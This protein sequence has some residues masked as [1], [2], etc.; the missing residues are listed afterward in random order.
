MSNLAFIGLGVMG[1]PMAGHLAQAGH[2]VTVYNRSSNKSKKW[3]SE[4]NGQIAA[5]PAEAA[6]DVLVESNADNTQIDRTAEKGESVA[7]G[8]QPP[9]SP[10]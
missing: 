1:F 7:N 6:K 2:S 4:Y 9:D 8:V 10:R 5:T 3:Y